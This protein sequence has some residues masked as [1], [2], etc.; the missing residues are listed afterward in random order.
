MNMYIIFHLTD[1]DI[2]GHDGLL[3]EPNIL[4]EAGHGLLGAGMAYMQGDVRGVL[5]AGTSL[6]KML[7]TSQENLEDVRR[8]KTSP[9]DVIQLSGCK[10]YQTSAD[11]MEGVYSRRETC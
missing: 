3:K 5:T 9:A 2:K 8:T 1:A 10:N 7:T 6:F 4:H 11:T